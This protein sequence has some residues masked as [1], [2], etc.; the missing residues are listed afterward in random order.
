MRHACLLQ[1]CVWVTDMFVPVLRLGFADWLCTAG[2]SDRDI[3]SIGYRSLRFRWESRV[4]ELEAEV[5]ALRTAC[6]C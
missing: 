1:A 2:D 3:F 5:A 4:A 6:R